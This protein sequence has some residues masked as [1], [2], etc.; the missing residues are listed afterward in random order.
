MRIVLNHKNKAALKKLGVSTMLTGI[1][2][3]GHYFQ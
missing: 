3:Q 1:Q 2:R